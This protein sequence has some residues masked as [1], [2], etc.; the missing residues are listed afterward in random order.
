VKVH[1]KIGAVMALLLIILCASLGWAIYAMAH[2]GERVTFEGHSY[3]IY[4]GQP[5]GHDPDCR[6]RHRKEGKEWRY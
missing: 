2:H 5:M 1:V 4:G 6:C 3:I